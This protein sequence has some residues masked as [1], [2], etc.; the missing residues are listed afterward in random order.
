[1]NNSPVAAPDDKGMTVATDIAASS[2]S[3]QAKYNHNSTDIEEEK[4]E[5]RAP[6][7]NDDWDDNNALESNEM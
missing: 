4:T 1:M 2:T 7:D 3:H 5:I 6:E